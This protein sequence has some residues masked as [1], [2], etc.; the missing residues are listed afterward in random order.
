MTELALIFGIS[1]L[2]LAFAAYLA[3]WVL[4]QP[5]GDGDMPRYAALIRG[6]AETFHRKQS[7]T[8]AAVSAVLGG[9][10]FLAYGLLRR[11]IQRT[12]GAEQTG[13]LR[14]RRRSGRL[15]ATLHPRYRTGHVVQIETGKHRPGGQGQER[16]QGKTA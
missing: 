3:R 11:D 10:I 13:G 8:I 5:A 9:A 7:S 15:V 4:A 1:A 14:G 12:E 6:V 2:G 16:C